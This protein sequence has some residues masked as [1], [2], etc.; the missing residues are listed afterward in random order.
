MAHS[1]E[2]EPVIYS[3]KKEA[4]S[5]EITSSVDVLYQSD[6][7]KNGGERL[8]DKL[9]RLAGVEVVQT[10]VSAGQ[11]A[12][13]LRGLDARHTAFA[14]DGVRVYD[15][16][17][18]QRLLNPS[19]ISAFDIERIEVLKGAQSV[20]Y[21]SDAIGGVINIITKK[22]NLKNEIGFDLGVQTRLNTSHSF[23]W[24][25]LS[26]HLKTFYQEDL[27]HNLSLIHI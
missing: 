20:L 6:L 22:N 3:S 15:A 27:V 2:I 18:I 7:K 13:F 26:L 17:S 8:S 24:N 23:L 19:L 21:G 12:V 4:L 5:S 11:A 10:G 1:H 14:I 9:K 16:A 25:K